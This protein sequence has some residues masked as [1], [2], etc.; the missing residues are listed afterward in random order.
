VSERCATAAVAKNIA[1]EVRRGIVHQYL[2]A[3]G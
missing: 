1:D 2:A 3:S